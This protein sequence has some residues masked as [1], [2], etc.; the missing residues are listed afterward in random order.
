MIS[1]KGMTLDKDDG[2]HDSMLAWALD[3]LEVARCFIRDA[4]PPDRANRFLRRIRSLQ[5]DLNP[6]FKEMERK[7]GDKDE[8]SSR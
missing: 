5:R 7:N 2:H 4:L 1:V 6:V 8:T 3:A